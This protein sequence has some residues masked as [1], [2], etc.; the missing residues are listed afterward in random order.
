LRVGRCR[1]VG[2]QERSAQTD[3]RAGQLELRRPLS[4]RRSG[5]YV[6]RWLIHAWLILRWVG[7]NIP[8]VVVGEEHRRIVHVIPREH[9]PL[10]LEQVFR[11]AEVR[12]Q[13]VADRTRRLH[14][15]GEG[16]HPGPQHGIAV[17]HRVESY[18]AVIGVHR[19]L[20]RV[21]DV[22]DLVVRQPGHPGQRVGG[23]LAQH[24][25]LRVRVVVQRRVAVEDPLD[26][27]VDHSRVGVAIDGEPGRNLGHPIPGMLI[28]DDL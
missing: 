11:V 8:E 7:R 1:N 28:I 13:L 3:Q 22:A 10:H 25:P 12:P 15:A 18:G 24:G 19:G 21:A 26:P 4:D 17:I 14:G 9:L 16:V 6:V 20:H 5:Q 23:R 27:T 2:G